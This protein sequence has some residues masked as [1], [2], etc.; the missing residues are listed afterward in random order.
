[1]TRQIRRWDTPYFVGGK[2]LSGNFLILDSVLAPDQIA[3][4]GC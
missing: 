3:L 4:F 1:M 2:H